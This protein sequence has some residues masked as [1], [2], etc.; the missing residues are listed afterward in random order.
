MNYWRGKDVMLRLSDEGKSA[1]Y[2]VY[3]TELIQVFVQWA[4]DAG[5]W[6]VRDR[7]KSSEI[8]VMLIKWTFFETAQFDL[9]LP[10]PVPGKAMGFRKQ[11]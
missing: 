3:D 10:E 1:L 9:I 4:D 7:R 5:L 6:V 11:G 2:G 8:S